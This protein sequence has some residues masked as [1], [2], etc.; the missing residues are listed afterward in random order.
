MSTTIH[1]CGSFYL[2][3]ALECS[4]LAQKFTAPFFKGRYEC[5]IIKCLMS[6]ASKEPN[7]LL[8]RLEISRNFCSSHFQNVAANSADSTF[9]DFKYLES[10]VTS[11]YLGI[12]RLQQYNSFSWRGKTWQMRMYSH[13]HFPQ[14]CGQKGL[15]TNAYHTLGPQNRKPQAFS[16]V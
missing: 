15:G 9:V 16:K 2:F 10:L 3:Y 4:I 5:F 7:R 6:R 12:L 13:D 14:S 1:K 11:G 8:S